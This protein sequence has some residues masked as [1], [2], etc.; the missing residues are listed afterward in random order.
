MPGRNLHFPLFFFSFFETQF[1][2]VTQAAVQWCILNSLQP[3]PPGFKQ[4]SCLSFP[5]SWYYRC[6]TTT[7]G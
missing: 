2:S 7:L 4:F 1:H 5:S 6:T 3:L